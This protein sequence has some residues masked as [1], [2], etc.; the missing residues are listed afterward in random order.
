MTD[1]KLHEEAYSEWKEQAAD[2]YIQ[3]QRRAFLDGFETAA[4]ESEQFNLL[5]DWAEEKRDE[6]T[7]KNEQ[8]DSMNWY[9]YRQAMI[10]LLVKL[11]EVGNHPDGESTNY[12]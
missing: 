7:Q 6:A 2:E 11:S 5:R 1:R 12:D 10:D 9:Y 8:D 4:T 3:A